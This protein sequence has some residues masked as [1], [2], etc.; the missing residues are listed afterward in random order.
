MTRTFDAKDVISILLGGILSQH[1]TIE[2][3]E[4]KEKLKT[5]EIDKETHKRRW[6]MKENCVNWLKSIKILRRT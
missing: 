1:D 6:E 4:W 2:D 3:L 5:I